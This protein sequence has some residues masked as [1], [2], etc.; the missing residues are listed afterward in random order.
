MPPNAQRH[1]R[2]FLDLPPEI[3]V[4][5]YEA[6]GLVVGAILRLNP[7]RSPLCHFL[8]LEPSRASLRF[9]YNILQT[10]RA[11]NAE[12]KTHICSQ[13]TLVVIDEHVEFGLAFLR[14]LN[15]QQCS[16]LTD[17]FVHLHLEA[18]VPSCFERPVW[19][20]QQQQSSPRFL[21]PGLLASWQATANHILSHTTPQTLS[22]RLFCDTGLGETT[23]AV[24]WPLKDFPGVLKDCELQLYHQPGD[25]R[26]CA[27]AWETCA[28]AKGLDPDLRNHPFR[29]FDL[30]TEIRR[31]ILEYTD[32]VTPHKE[33]Y[34]SSAEGF[35]IACVPEVCKAD[36][37]AAHHD[38]G[39]FVQICAPCPTLMTG[40]LCCRRR[41]GYSSRCQCWTPPKA[42][43]L[44]SRALYQEALPVLYSRNRIVVVP[45][46]G[47]RSYLRLDNTATR[48]DAS[49]F[50]T[51]H[52]WPDVLRNLRRLD[53][54]LPALYPT[55]GTA[56][57]ELVSHDLCFAM[58]HLKAHLDIPRLTLVVYM[59]Q[60]ILGVDDT[61]AMLTYNKVL[62][63]LK[64]LQG[65]KRFFVHILSCPS[66][67]ATHPYIMA[68][69]YQPIINK[70]ESK[71]EKI[72]MGEEYSSE[73]AGKLNEQPSLWLRNFWR[74]RGRE[75]W[76]KSDT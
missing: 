44:T 64:T 4:R 27:I 52:M 61:L 70:L 41:S 47:L 8:P 60:P 19:P 7:R 24:L 29:F 28:R 42:L 45:S 11:I 33:V 18:P 30:P 50:I 62:G 71:L 57:N 15:P 40:Y 48:L 22:L 66:G 1:A 26:L 39:S 38:T 13:N 14:S 34:W 67:L 51:R 25:K 17:L 54:V 23:F 63:S 46:G 72:V 75:V 32:L 69:G 21:P 68:P 74:Y 6:A 5:I 55:T 3:R 37:C 53:F 10:C 35:R 2:C 73:A 9:T 65:M 12:V 36:N 59:L 16:V 31:H 49:R 76:Q 58:E 56:Y 20:P 43:I